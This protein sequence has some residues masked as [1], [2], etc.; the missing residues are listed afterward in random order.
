MI[1]RA[2]RG[3]EKTI[4]KKIGARATANSGASGDK[5]DMVYKALEHEFRIEA[6]STQAGGLT[7]DL[8]WLVKIATE[9]AERGQVPALTATFTDDVGRN[10]KSGEWVMLPL[11]FFREVFRPRE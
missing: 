8:G 2:G 1:G 4:A 9:A 7:V 6:K 5:G 11:W 3:S 10:R